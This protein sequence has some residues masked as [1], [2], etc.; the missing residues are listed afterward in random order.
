MLLDAE[1]TPFERDLLRSWSDEQPA[2]AARERAMALATVAAG[3]AIVGASGALAPKAI[4]ATTLAIVKWLAIGSALVAVGVG[5]AAIVLP[6]RASNATPTAATATL[7]VATLPRRDQ[8]AP[9]EGASESTEAQAAIESATRS[10]R[11]PPR[12]VQP[13]LPALGDEIASIDR[14]RAA[15]AAG[16]GVRGGQLVDEYERRFPHGTFTQEAEVLRVEALELRADR[17]GARRA[18]ERFLAAHP[19][20]PHAPRLRAIVKPQ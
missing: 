2:P 5:G 6:D 3:V 17:A 13:T 20:S 10:S 1:V 18:A 16:D 14:A 9:R 8:A 7:R 15:I 4:S 11:V 19:A 12:A